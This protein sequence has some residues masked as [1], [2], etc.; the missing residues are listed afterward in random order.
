MV[1]TDELYLK[2]TVPLEKVV[3]LGLKILTYFNLEEREGKGL[4]QFGGGD[5]KNVA[6]CNPPSST[7][8]FWIALTMLQSYSYAPVSVN[9]QRGLWDYDNDVQNQEQFWNLK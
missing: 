3:Y 8:F 5:V 6:V 7:I 4:F 1:L 2:V 9:P